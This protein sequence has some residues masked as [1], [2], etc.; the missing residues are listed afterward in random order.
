MRTS[1]MLKFAID[2]WFS[3]CRDLVLFTMHIELNGLLIISSLYAHCSVHLPRYQ[4]NKGQSCVWTSAHSITGLVGCLR[5]S[6]VTSAHAPGRASPEIT[7]GSYIQII[8]GLNISYVPGDLSIF[9]QDTSKATMVIST[10]FRPV[11]TF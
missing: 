1:N 10:I 8:L 11:L 4:P 7:S 6:V 3:A 5:W 2:I 9:F